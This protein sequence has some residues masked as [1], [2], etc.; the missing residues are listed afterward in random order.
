MSF[1][2]HRRKIEALLPP[3]LAASGAYL[4]ELSVKHDGRGKLVRVLIDT[5]AGITIG[6]CAEISR[7]LGRLIDA[8]Q[9]LTE[10]YRLEVSSPGIDQPLRLLRQYAKNVG[11]R[12]TVRYRTGE[13]TRS[14]SAVLERVEG[15]QIL[16]RLEAGEELTLAFDAIV[17]SKEILPW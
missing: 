5:D 14:A 9:V 12:Y 4:V 10:T 6:Q 7:E 13:E 3:V 17:E 1:E 15:D 16:F 2:Q 8:G 11:R